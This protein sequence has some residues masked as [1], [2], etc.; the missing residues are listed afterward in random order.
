MNND[1]LDKFK[2]TLASAFDHAHH[3]EIEQPIDLAQLGGLIRFFDN[4]F[5]PQQYGCEKLRPLLEQ[6]PDVIQLIKDETITPPRY[7]ANYIG[8]SK[9]GDATPQEP[10]TG[11]PARADASRI[12]DKLHEFAVIIKAKWQELA[13]L[14]RPEYWGDGDDL[15]LLRNYVRYTFSRLVYE[16]K[17]KVATGGASA[18]F[19]TGLVDRR[20][21]PIFALLVKSNKAGMAPW[22]L[23]GFCVAG[24]NYN[25]KALVK[26]FNPLP[27][28]AYYFTNRDDAF[29]DITAAPP[30]IDW[31]HV[32]E[33]NADRIPPELLTRTTHGFEVKCCDGMSEDQIE[34]YKQQ[35]AD[36][37]KKDGFAYRMLIDAFTR[38]LDLALKKVR[39]NYKTA[40][41]VYSPAKNKLSMLLPLCMLSEDHVDLALVVERTG[42]G[43]YQGQT[44]YPLDWAYSNSRLIARPES[45]WLHAEDT[46]QP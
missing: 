7:F 13:E 21:Q 11:I 23:E 19:N 45:E 38:A 41:P 20:F 43:N 32:I 46:D 6:M 18:A 12:S 39:W 36:Y 44:I 10:R 37:L 1:N 27:D 5:S 26:T 28:A 29:Y 4:G 16:Q 9:K 24:E 35:L 15:T 40:I 14:A 42:S 22:F 8:V 31:E 2:V 34:E 30:Y 33:E 3:N 17:V 25:G